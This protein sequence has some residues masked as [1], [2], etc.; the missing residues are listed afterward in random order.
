MRGGRRSALPTPGAFAA[1]L[2]MV[3]SAQTHDAVS[4][5]QAPS[6]YLGGNVSAINKDNSQVLIAAG[7]KQD[8]LAVNGTDSAGPGTYHGLLWFGAAASA[9]DLN[10]FP[11]TGY[12]GAPIDAIDPVSDIIAGAA[13]GPK[14]VFEPAVWVPVP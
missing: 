9:I 5:L 8:G 4:I 7:N 11:P 12:T 13:K 10:Q 14:G 1:T 3:S 2:P 6:P